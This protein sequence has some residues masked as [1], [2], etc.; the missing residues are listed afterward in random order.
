MSMK[1][2]NKAAI[3]FSFITSSSLLFSG[4]MAVGNMPAA[5]D[6]SVVGSSST[7]LVG[8][9][10]LSPPLEDAEQRTHWNVIGDGAIKNRMLIFTHPEKTS[11]NREKD[12]SFRGMKNSI[13][14]NLGET[15]FLKAPKQ[16]TN[17]LAGMVSLELS[18]YSNDQLYFP[19]GFRINIEPDDQAVYIGTLI[20]HR[21]DFHEIVKVELKDEFKQS[22]QQ[23]KE[24]FGGRVQLKKSLLTK[25]K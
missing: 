24:K 15:F 5:V 10:Q 25:A 13:I 4:C 11:F 20:Y 8:K 1:S 22:K 17:I 6:L 7:I 18:G 19:G 3:Y 23:F 21:N 16:S 9:V 2:F 12:Y 14:A